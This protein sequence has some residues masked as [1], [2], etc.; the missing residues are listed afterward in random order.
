MGAGR[1]RRF[2]GTFGGF[3]D[4]PHAHGLGGDPDPANFS[5]NNGAHT[6]D[7][8]F[9][10]AFG[11]ARGLDTHAAEILGLAPPGDGPA[12]PGFLTC[13]IAFSRH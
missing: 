3:H 1:R 13:E 5:V 10:F 12:R 2:P 7:I 6:L 4:Q 8:G 9:E 11:N